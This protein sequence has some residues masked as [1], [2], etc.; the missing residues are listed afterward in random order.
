[1]WSKKTEFRKIRGQ[2][3]KDRYIRKNRKS[4]WKDKGCKEYR[5]KYIRE[6]NR[7]PSHSTQL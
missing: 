4:R 6:L 3:Y 1:M 7:F 5:E 2:L